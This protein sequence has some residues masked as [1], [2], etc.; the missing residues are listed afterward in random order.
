MNF[1]LIT[2]LIVYHHIIGNHKEYTIDLVI[3]G[4]IIFRYTDLEGLPEFNDHNI[5]NKTNYSSGNDYGRY[6]WVINDGIIDITHSSNREDDMD[7]FVINC[8]IVINNE[9]NLLFLTEIAH[10]KNCIINKIEHRLL[11]PNYNSEIVIVNEN[12]NKYKENIDNIIDGIS[13]MD[14]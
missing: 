14:I 2:K 8:K 11:Y 1:A 12:N 6:S 5:P 3:N 4:C 7:N 9:Q 13:E 10:L